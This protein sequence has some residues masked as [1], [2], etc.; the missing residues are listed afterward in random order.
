MKAKHLCSNYSRTR[1]AATLSPNGGEGRERRHNQV[2]ALRSRTSCRNIFTLLLGT[3][4]ALVPGADAQIAETYTLTDITGWSTNQLATLPWF[5]HWIPLQPPGAPVGFS[6]AARNGSGAVAGDAPGYYPT[7]DRGAVV[8]DN[9]ATYISAW[10]GHSW[11]YWVCDPEDCHYYWGRVEHSPATDVNALGLIVGHATIE[12]PHNTNPLDYDEH[13]Y[14]FDPATGL[15]TNLTPDGTGYARAFRLNDLG[16][17]IGNYAGPS[18]FFA[19]RRE[20]DGTMNYF[21]H[22]VA[23]VQPMVLNNAGLVAGIH[24]TYTVSNRIVVPWIASNTTAMTAIPLPPQGNP[25]TCTFTGLNNH[26]LLVGYA[27][28][29]AAWYETTAVRWHAD[30]DG[31]W[32]AQDLNEI[33]DAGDYVLDRVLAVNDAGY[34]IVAA[35]LDTDAKPPRTLMLTP[36]VFPAPTVVTLPPLSLTPTSAVLRAQV[37]A[38]NLA[39]TAAFHWGLAPP[40][41]ATNPAAGEAITGTVPS[42]VTCLL[43]NLQPHTTYHVRVEA[44]NA[45]GAALGGDLALTTPYDYATWAAERFGPAVTNESLAGPQANPDGDPWNNMNEFA[46]GLD[47]QAADLGVL[48]PRTELGR[49]TLTLTHPLDRAGVTLTFAAS[50]NLAGPWRSGPGA[51]ALVNL[52]RNGNLET[53]TVRTDFPGTQPRQFLRLTVHDNAQP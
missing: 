41:T 34:L 24:T 46:L 16:V 47:P 26:G 15:K 20:A 10:G 3:L 8:Q 35:H 30:P 36:D 33:L 9:A 25:D 5:A 37:N 31:N 11:S 40:Y 44:H 43:T 1:P 45:Q 38:C 29:M 53:L 6:A 12:T 19:F 13:A 22:P 27:N 17:V 21:T 32:I 52:T 14:L 4:L 23:T 28:K 51:T 50:T 49:L 39:T 18:N 7:P 42:I 48:Q 2:Q